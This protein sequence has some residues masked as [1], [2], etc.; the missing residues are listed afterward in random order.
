MYIAL[1]VPIGIMLNGLG[2]KSVVV[3]FYLCYLTVNLMIG[4]IVHAAGREK[5]DILYIFIADVIFVL[6]FRD[7]ILTINIAAAFVAS[8][9]IQYPEDKKIRMG[10]CCSC[11]DYGSTSYI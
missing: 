8:A 9:I 3:L 1:S 7:M 6:L 10:S 2:I 11:G 5:W 4:M